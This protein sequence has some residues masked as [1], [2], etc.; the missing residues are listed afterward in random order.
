M[1]AHIHGS[2]LASS[3]YLVTLPRMTSRVAIALL[4]NRDIFVCDSGAGAC[5]VP[6]KASRPDHVFPQGCQKELYSYP[7]PRLCWEENG[8]FATRGYLV[9]C[10]PLP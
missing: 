5:Q 2:F 4:P 8:R 1:L 6:E 3:L 10:M 9:R 7:R